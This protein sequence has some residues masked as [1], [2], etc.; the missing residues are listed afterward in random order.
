[1]YASYLPSLLT[2]QAQSS[3]LIMSAAYVI[4][5]DE[6]TVT[7]TIQVDETVTTTNNRV[8]FF[9]C[10]E[11]IHDQTNLVRDVLP[12]ELFTLSSP[13]ESTLV[14]RQFT[15]P[16]D[17]DEENLRVIIL[18]QSQ[19]T[20]EILQATLASADYAATLVV[21]CD[22]D[23]VEAPWRLQ[24]PEGLDL[25]GAGDRT[26]QLFFTGEY[27]VTW[28]P[29][30][31]WEVPSESP[32]AQFIGEGETISFL[33][34]YTG[35]PFAARTDGPLGHD[36]SSQGVALIDFDSD[37]DLDLHVVQAGTADQLL[38]NNGGGSFE[39]VADGLLADAGQGRSAAWA[40][41]NH[42]GFVDLYLGKDGEANLL[43]AGDGAGG[44]TPAAAVG[45]D[46]AGPAR[47][48]SFVDFNLD[49]ILDIY[50]VNYGA[51]NRLLRSLGD[52]G[53][54][55]YIFTPETGH[56]ANEGQ[57]NAAAWGDA[58]LDGRP[59]LYLVNAFNANALLGNLAIGFDDVTGNAGLDNVGN[60]SGAAWGDYDN[61]GDLDLYLANH[62]M[63][64]VLFRNS[65]NFAFSTVPGENLG[66]PGNGRGVVWA[67]FDNDTNLDLY[68]S[69]QDQQDLMLLGDGSGSFLRV[70]VGVA[71][72]GMASNAVACGDID[73][74]GAVDLFISRQDESN[75][76]MTNSLATSLGAGNHWFGVH[77]RGV[78]DNTSGLGARV[79]LTAGGITQT[80][81]ISSG[82]GFL[83][84]SALGAH[85]G[86]GVVDQVDRVDVYWPNGDH[87]VIENRAAD[88]VIHVTQGEDPISPVDSAEIPQVNR[89]GNAYPNPFNPMT[90]IEFALAQPGVTRLEV[91]TVDGRRIRTLVSGQLA[92]GPHRVTWDG[93]DRSGRRV[94]S[95]SYFYRLTTADGYDGTG[96][97]VLVK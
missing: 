34:A 11:G 53:G 79:T 93:T 26:L 35:G 61:D 37:G 19:T 47:S 25:S 39:D 6:V 21:D 70:P 4:L 56:V 97:M 8:H 40:D 7:T 15:L 63:A 92:S 16:S 89:L 95:G 58:D 3:P 41:Y 67:D 86:L 10:G 1:M 33:G 54:G 14:E 83:S 13:G 96:R 88:Q 49:G 28:Q 57:G 59:E 30:P 73:G 32:Q 9:V 60:G 45:I 74:D 46:D 18:V 12:S 87:Q 24:G 43:L 64:D 91:Y 38:R 69:R 22:P 42:D 44:F 65:G 31:A 50:T 82:A 17:V 80:R 66:D 62:G 77:L 81:F 78:T 75:V 51:A 71:E 90:T 36:G 72:A 5:G 52:I 23:G 29:I 68:I 85:F 55:L 27:T 48:V 20:D 2:R 76:L 94:A 84:S